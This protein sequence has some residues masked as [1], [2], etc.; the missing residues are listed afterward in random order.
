MAGNVDTQKGNQSSTLTAGTSI[1]VFTECV[2][3]ESRDT[4]YNKLIA[5]KLPRNLRCFDS[6]GM[7]CFFV[8]IYEEL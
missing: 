4:F 3:S 1:D 7:C 2:I 5:L 6:N 8:L